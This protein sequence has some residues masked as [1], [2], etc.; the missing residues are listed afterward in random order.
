[1]EFLLASSI[2]C[3]QLFQVLQRMEKNANLFHY[4]KVAIQ[5]VLIREFPQCRIFVNPNGKKLN[6]KS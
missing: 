4:Q 6:H 2:S 1:M 5:K 3:T